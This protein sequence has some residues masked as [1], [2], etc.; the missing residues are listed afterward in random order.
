M[1]KDYQ[2]AL[3]YVQD[4]FQMD[5]KKFI[6]KYFKGERI[7]EIQRNITSQKYQQL[8]GQLSKRQ[9]DIISDK[10]SRYIVGF[11]V[12]G[13]VVG[14][15]IIGGYLIGMPV[16]HHQ[17]AEMRGGVVLKGQSV[18]QSDFGTVVI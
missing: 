9:M 5:Y 14:R 17:H 11:P 10:D 7:N 16:E 15:K 13:R 12:P 6:G 8:F 2:S 4:Y 18:V 1:V 3:Q